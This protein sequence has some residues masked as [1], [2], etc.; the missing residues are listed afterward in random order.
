L[1]LSWRC[2]AALSVSTCF[3]HDVDVDWERLGRYVIARRVKLGYRSR[4]PFAA[5]L[6][7]STRVLGDIET[8]RRSNYDPTTLASLED[9]LGWETGS[10]DRV[11]R[12]GDPILAPPAPGQPE[13]P[14]WEDRL[15][16]VQAIADN[17]DRTPGL[18]AWA[19]NQVRQ[20]EELL[21]AAH[22]EEEAQRRGKAS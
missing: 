20:I 4:E 12:G 3:R 6:K 13:E 22:A 21:A 8:G 2:H 18:R 14:D 15:A 10:I 7:I 5:A 19:A 16:K 9:V 17:P 11:L 1:F